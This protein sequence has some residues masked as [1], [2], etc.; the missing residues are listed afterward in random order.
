MAESPLKSLKKGKQYEI[1]TKVKEI[2]VKTILK[3]SWID[4]SSKLVGFD[5]GN[6]IRR[7]AFQPGNTA[8]IKLSEEKFIK[9]G[10]ISNRGELVLEP[11][12]ECDKPEFLK[13]RAVRVE[14]DPVN[15]VKVKLKVGERE[16]ETQ[17]KDISEYGVGVIFRKDSPEGQEILKLLDEK[18]GE[19]VDL[20]LELPKYGHVHAKGRVRR[21]EVHDGEVYIRFGFELEFS[22]EHR[23]KVRKYILDRQQ[24]I[25]KSLRLL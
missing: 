11:Q 21:K 2:P 16:Y 20:E 12:E 22:E 19:W 8:Y 6:C 25:V 18:K 1:Y 5:W 17:A 24:E 23:A 4:Q 13:R 14:V 3:L 9:S 7:G 15:P 10:I